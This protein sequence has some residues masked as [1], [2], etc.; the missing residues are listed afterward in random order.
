MRKKNEVTTKKSEA[1]EEN[2][3]GASD[4]ERGLMARAFFITE[5][6]DTETNRFESAQILEYDR[7][8]RTQEA[9]F[10]P[11]GYAMLDQTYGISNL[12]CLIKDDIA[13]TPYSLINIRNGQIY[14]YRARLSNFINFKIDSLTSCFISEMITVLQDGERNT[15]E[16]STVLDIPA[17]INS[18]PCASVFY[19]GLSN[20]ISEFSN[21][22]AIQIAAYVLRSRDYKYDNLADL[23]QEDTALIDSIVVA[24]MCNNITLQLYNNVSRFL[25]KLLPLYTTTP[26]EYHIHQLDPLFVKYHDSVRDLLVQLEDTYDTLQ[27]NDTLDVYTTIKN[28]KSTGSVNLPEYYANYEY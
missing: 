27:D 24:N 6:V 3:T 5:A 12:N 22:S 18:N 11:Y 20:S 23:N 15:G 17:F 8:R 4:N 9:Q 1:V 19:Q 16:H 13:S 2:S 14:E 21:G 25:F 10:S 26:A 7:Q 28:N